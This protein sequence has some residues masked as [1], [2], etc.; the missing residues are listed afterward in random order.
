ML[1]KGND[2]VDKVVTLVRKMVGSVRK[3]HMDTDHLRGFQCNVKPPGNT[4]LTGEYSMLESIL[5]AED[6]GALNDL[7]LTC[8]P[9]SRYHSNVIAKLMSNMKPLMQS[10][11]DSQCDDDTTCTLLP[12]L[13]GIHCKLKKTEQEL[14][15]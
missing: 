2:D 7:S 15:S 6:K 13:H 8:L 11:L 14:T 5:D 3:S 1:S 12:N 4:C 9:L 10:T